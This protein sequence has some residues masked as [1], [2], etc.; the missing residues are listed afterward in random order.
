MQIELNLNTIIVMHYKKG[1]GDTRKN[2]CQK[3]ARPSPPPSF[4]SRSI[5]FK[6]YYSSRR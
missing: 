4:D 6:I 3:E 1:Q 2:T 5:E